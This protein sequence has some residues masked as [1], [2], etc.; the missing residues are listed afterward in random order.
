MWTIVSNTSC[1]KKQ[2]KVLSEVKVQL[3]F[4]I[5]MVKN[6]SLHNKIGYFGLHIFVW[7]VN[8]IYVAFKNAETIPNIFWDCMGL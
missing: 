6:T 3:I 4:N 8:V 7:K 2:N 5:C 1:S